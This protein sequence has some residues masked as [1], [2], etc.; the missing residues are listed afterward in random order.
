MRIVIC[1][2]NLI[3]SLAC[4]I[5]LAGGCGGTA[6][7]GGYTAGTR[8]DATVSGG[9]DG[10]GAEGIGGADTSGT[11]GSAGGTGNSAGG[12]GGGEASCSSGGSSQTRLLSPRA[13]SRSPADSPAAAA[14]VSANSQ[15]ELVSRC[16][17]H[18]AESSSHRRVP[19]H[20]PGIRNDSAADGKLFGTVL[21]PFAKRSVSM[22]PF[23]FNRAA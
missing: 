4:G 9:T 10:G 21:L 7:G 20:I 12:S 13:V 22:V 14:P 11:G 15:S 6:A 8:G 19:A 2:L 23:G 5:A 3:L 17:P 1:D 16:F 18:F